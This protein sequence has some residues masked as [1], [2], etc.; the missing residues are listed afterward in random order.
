MGAKS[1]NNTAVAVALNA[2]QDP[3]NT[4]KCASLPKSRN[5]RASTGIQ[6]ELFNSSY[7]TAEDEDEESSDELVTSTSEDDSIL[8]SKKDAP[9]KKASSATP[10]KKSKPAS[11]G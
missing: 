2:Q 8:G 3:T 4:Q 1:E 5:T 11:G 10:E 7:Y 6:I 9:P